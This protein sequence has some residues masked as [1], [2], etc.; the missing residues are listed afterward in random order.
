MN[1]PED[2]AAAIGAEP[3]VTA[4]S[5][6]GPAIRRHLAA[7]DAAMAALIG[8]VGRCTMKIERTRE[9]YEALIRAIAHQ[10]IHGRA[11]EA[12]LGRML[13]L[14][15][16]EAFL[17]PAALLGLSDA[18]LRGAGLSGAKLAAMRGVAQ[19][20]LDG[21]VPSRA[22]AARLSDAVLIERLTT[23]RGIGRW[24]VE[25]LLIFSLCRRDIMPVDDFGVREG[26]RRIKEL[27]RQLTPGAMAAATAHLAPFRSVAA[28]YLWRAAEER[29]GGFKAPASL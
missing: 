7:A 2:A 28:W 16:G 4:V 20:T 25:M 5:A 21:V 10:Q 27:E 1:S 19:A 6:A 26:W 29:A 17:P 13:A 23:L 9:P 22:R 8:R 14:H 18:A 11:A 24:T 12:I 15:A 3:I